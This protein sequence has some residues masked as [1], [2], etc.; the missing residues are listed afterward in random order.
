MRLRSLRNMHLG[1][2]IQP[3]DPG[4]SYCCVIYTGGKIAQGKHIKLEEGQDKTLE[5]HRKRK[6]KGR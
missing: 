5:N 4:W 3:L 2:G 6:D 1:F